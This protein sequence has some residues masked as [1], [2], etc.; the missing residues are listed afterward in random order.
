[1]K[2]KFSFAIAVLLVL[3]IL[4]LGHSRVAWADKPSDQGLSARNNEIQSVAVDRDDDDDDDDRGTVKPPPKKIIITKSG[5]YSVGGFCTIT[6]KIYAQN[7]KAEVSIKRP[8]PRRLPDNVHRV[9]QGCLVTYFRDDKRI[10]S[11]TPNLGTTKICFAAMPK[12][13]IKIYFYN[14]YSKKPTWTPLKTTVKDGMACATGIGSG[15]YV[16]TF[17]EH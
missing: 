15:V 3:S 17:R 9:Y 13:Q 5:S 16:A 2:Q 6:I 11:L 12:K 14:M 10:Q 8:L 1:M 4:L 7:I